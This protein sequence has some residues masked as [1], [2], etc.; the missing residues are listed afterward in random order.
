MPARDGWVALNLPRVD[1]RA[2]LPALFCNGELA[3]DDNEAVGAAMALHSAAEIVARGREIGLAIAHLDEAPAGPASIVSTI[4]DQREPP[5]HVPLVVDLTALWAG[6]LAGHLLW[7]AGAHVVKVESSAR[8]DAMRQGD[9]ALFALLNQGKASVAL[10]LR[11]PADR[12]ALVAL[13]RRADI[14]LEAARPRALHQL[15]I[16]GDTIVRETPGLNWVTIKGHGVLGAAG[17]W[18]GFGDDCGVAGGLSAA[19]RAATG[20]VGFVGDAIAD[21]LTGLSAATVAW[22][23]WASG[24]G[25]RIIL[26]MSGTVRAVM[27]MER[28]GLDVV[29]RHWANSVGRPF[30]TPAPRRPSAPVATIGQDNA[31]WLAVRC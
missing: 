3:V 31:A 11:D 29:L 25:G 23:R 20:A 26:S 24:M 10:D 15:G 2:V 9:P 16:D 19:L 5:A 13:I 30:P 18:I 17:D 4:A 6:P 12:D 21:P 1:D 22:D 28:E 7:L 8:P 27:E 14:V